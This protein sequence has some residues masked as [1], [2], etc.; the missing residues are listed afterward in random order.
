MDKTKQYIKMADTPKIQEQRKW[1]SEWDGKLWMFNQ[2]G[3]WIAN[4]KLVGI[5]EKAVRTSSVK[6]SPKLIWLPTQSQLQGMVGFKNGNEWWLLDIFHLWTK[7]TSLADIT[8][9]EQLWL[10]FCLKT[11]YN[12]V[13]NGSEWITT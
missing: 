2:D 1:I 12:K 3:D 9:M 13:W 6:N 8:S 11:L 7:E 4:A 10:S 5:A